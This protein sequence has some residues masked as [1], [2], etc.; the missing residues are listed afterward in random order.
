MG[1]APY[2]PGGLSNSK[3]KVATAVESDVVSGKTFYAGD[4]TLKTGELKGY[5]ASPSLSYNA[6]RG[7]SATSGKY[8]TPFH[9]SGLSRYFVECAGASV[10]KISK[11]KVRVTVRARGGWACYG[12]SDFYTEKSWTFD[13]ALD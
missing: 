2:T 10:A 9:N 12:Y 3:L 11:D 8:N 1:T 7:E 13:V 6:D 5:V 4:K